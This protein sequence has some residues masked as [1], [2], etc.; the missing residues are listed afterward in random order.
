MKVKKSN[1]I[2]EVS[3]KIKPS[4]EVNSKLKRIQHVQFE[5]R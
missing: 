4:E 3:L 2:M 1:W 5:I